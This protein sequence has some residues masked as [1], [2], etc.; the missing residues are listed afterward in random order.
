MI[1]FIVI[2]GLS[3][4]GKTTIAKAL[5]E[6]IDGLYMKPPIYPLSEI[7]EKIDESFSDEARALF[8]L[9]GIVEI[10]NRIKKVAIQQ[11]VV[12]DKYIY[13]T[14]IYPNTKGIKITWP[15]WADI[16]KPDLAIQLTLNEEI[17]LTRLKDRGSDL[18]S[19][20]QLDPTRVAEILEGYRN[21]GLI[22]VS[23]DEAVSKTIDKIMNLLKCL[24]EN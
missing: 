16:I 18:K 22:Q 14:L 11:P 23:N 7:R 4:T 1:K 6:K 2:E 5:A 21:Y 13:T 12:L 19:N 9:S 15:E 8:Y 10:S 3:G 17:R 24:P 20:T